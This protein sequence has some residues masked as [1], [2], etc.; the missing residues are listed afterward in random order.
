[1]KKLSLAKTLNLSLLGI[2][3]LLSA[4]AHEGGNMIATSS[5]P[6]WVQRMACF[7]PQ[8]KII[9]GVG[10][11]QHIPDLSL[12]Q[13][14]ADVRAR[15]VVAQQ[16]KSYMAILTKSYQNSVAGGA[17]EDQTAAEQEASS[18]MKS[19][20][21][22]TLRGVMIVDHYRDADGTVFAKA[23]IDLATFKNMVKNYN[24]MNEKMK[25]AIEKDADKSF[26][27]LSKEESKH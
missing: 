6:Q 18:T 5:A 14:T 20:T 16:L 13:Q 12:A 2:L 24:Q 19:F 26:D 21:K 17:N 1:M 15:A 3:P 9:C 10:A 7:D 11:A 23:Q 25:Q 22:T 27:E 8:Q 4:C